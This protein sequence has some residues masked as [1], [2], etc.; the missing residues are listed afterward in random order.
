M[1]LCSQLGVQQLN[2]MHKPVQVNFSP[3]QERYTLEE[4]WALPEPENRVRYNL[5]GGYLFMVLPPDPP[6]G[7]VVS[8]MGRALMRFLIANDVSGL[9]N[10]PPGPICDSK[11]STY[12]LPD[13]MYVSGELRKR[14]GPISTSA[15]I[16]IECLTGEY[17]RLRSHDE[18]RHVSRT[19][20]TRVV[21]DRSGHSHYRSA[22][23][24]RD[25]RHTSMGD[26]PVRK[27]RAREISRAR[28][29]GSFS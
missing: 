28:W 4:F 11:S 1:L 8:N 14:M 18:S 17:G 3:L 19:R 10:F 12:L 26:L 25:Q 9:V 27:R 2:V 7:E 20:R 15:D 21:V 16:V 23:P 24:E 13:L 5:I 22:P 6:H 29:L